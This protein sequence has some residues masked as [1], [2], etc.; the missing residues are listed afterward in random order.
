M[1]APCAIGN[2]CTAQNALCID[3]RCVCPGGYF[4]KRDGCG[5]LLRIN[6]IHL[7]LTLHYMK[8]NVI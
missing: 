5:K 4:P 3:G 2:I 7:L 1:Y 6:V 8:H